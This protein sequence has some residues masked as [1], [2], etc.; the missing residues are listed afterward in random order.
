MI[1]IRSTELFR[2]I[3]RFFP[4]REYLIITIPQ[5]AKEPAW[6]EHFVVGNFIF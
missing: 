5:G 3:F 1:F 6:L 4:N 2:E